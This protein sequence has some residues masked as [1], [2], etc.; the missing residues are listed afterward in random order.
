MRYYLSLLKDPHSISDNT[1]SAAQ[2]V[3]TVPETG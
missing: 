2:Q 3:H 1:M